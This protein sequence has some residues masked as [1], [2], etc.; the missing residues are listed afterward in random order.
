MV[1]T[2]VCGGMRGHI[3]AKVDIKCILLLSPLFLGDR[4][5]N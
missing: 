2:H 3:D 4:L 1:D 5:I